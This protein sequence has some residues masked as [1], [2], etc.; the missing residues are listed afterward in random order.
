MDGVLAD[1]EQGFLARWRARY[2]DKP[3][4]PI[5]DRTTFY[6]LDQY[7]QELS[8]LIRAIQY[9]PGFIR[10]LRPVPGA[11]E[12]MGAMIEAG[13]DVFIC[14][15]PFTRYEHCVQEKYAWVDEH[16]GHEWIRRVIL[17]KDKTLIKGDVLIDDRPNVRGV[18]E[19]SWEHIVF[20]QPYNRDQHDKRRLTGWDDW[21]SVLLSEG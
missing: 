20:D 17:A 1:F 16:L 15:S 9:A 3:Y 5:E 18:A 14:S 7:P 10:E 6:I 8:P 13:L 4:I 21:E 12:A 11:I 2:P 19:P